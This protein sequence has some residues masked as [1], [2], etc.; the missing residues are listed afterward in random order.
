MS[1]PKLFFCASMS[2]FYLL[3]LDH[4]P[5]FH[6]L[7]SLARFSTYPSLL[8][9]SFLCFPTHPSPP[10][11]S[12]S[13]LRPKLLWLFNFITKTSVLLSLF[14]FTLSTPLSCSH[15]LSVSLISPQPILSPSLFLPF[16]PYK[17][18]LSQHKTVTFLHPSSTSTTTSHSP[19]PRYHLAYLAH[20]PSL[21]SV[22]YSCV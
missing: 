13:N 5:Q 21:T 19:W 11:F 4:Q 17:C 10:M 20:L 8:F 16:P 2:V 7:F 3:P 14:S 1:L 12:I 18:L 22:S 15:S 6:I 9:V